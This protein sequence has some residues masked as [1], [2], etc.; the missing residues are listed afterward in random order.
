MFTVDLDRVGEVTVDEI[1]RC[2][3][4]PGLDTR[5]HQAEQPAEAHHQGRCA[6]CRDRTRRQVRQIARAAAT[7]GEA[8]GER[9]LADCRVDH[10][11]VQPDGRDG[12][13]IWIA[14]D[15]HR[16]ERYGAHGVAQAVA[17]CRGV[18]RHRPMVA[19]R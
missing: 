9:I 10:A 1:A 15:D 8:D 12:G 5:F 13:C 11:H 4:D 3:A 19:D 6:A 17:E 14:T 16:Y 2:Q 7:E 18:G